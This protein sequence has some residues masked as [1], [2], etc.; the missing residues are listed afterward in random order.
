MGSQQLLL[1]VVGLVLI[2]IA[3]AV[4]MTMFAD[5]ATSENRD[6]LA[7]DLA[8]F[9]SIARSYY[10][11]PTSFGGGGYSFKGLTMSRITSKPSNDN[12]TYSLTPDPV[13]GNP[14]FVTLTGIGTQTGLDGTTNVKVVMLVYPDSIKMDDSQIN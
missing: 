9:G 11:K 12:G 10:R 8:H 2:G 14:Q 1:I 5:Q 6:N 3:I 4:G 7:N 13:T